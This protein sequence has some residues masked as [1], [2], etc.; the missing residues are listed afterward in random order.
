MEVPI[1]V[2]RARVAAGSRR[3]RDLDAV[4]DAD[5]IAGLDLEKVCP[6]MQES[7]EAWATIVTRCRRHF[8]ESAVEHWIAP[9][10]LV[11][12]EGDVLVMAGDRKVV[13]WAEKR[14]LRVINEIAKGETTF[15]SVRIIDQRGQRDA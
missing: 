6:P 13:Y 4:Q 11:G 8:H 2:R 14:Y 10:K 12:S 15:K 5:W 3:K 1:E 9:L 7:R